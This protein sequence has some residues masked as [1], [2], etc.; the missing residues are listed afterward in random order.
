MP[1]Q[2]EALKIPGLAEALQHG[3]VSA[4]EF[5]SGMF[6]RAALR[7]GVVGCGRITRVHV[8]AIT[9]LPYSSLRF[10]IVAIADPVP[11]S[12][13]NVLRL[14]QTRAQGNS[15]AEEENAKQPAVTI[16]QEFV[17][18][19]DMLAALG[20]RLELDAVLLALPHDVHESAV[21][22]ALHEKHN[23]QAVI[24]EKPFGINAA[25]MRRML[26][27]ER[28]NPNC[29]LFVAEQSPWWPEVKACLDVIRS[30]QIGK[31]VSAHAHYFESLMTTDFWESAKK[32]VKT[33]WRW[34]VERSGGGMIMDG[35]I[36]WIRA[37]RIWLGDVTSVIACMS[38]PVAV[39]CQDG[40]RL[41]LLEGETISHA[42][43][44]FAC[45]VTAS[46]QTTMLA[47]GPV[48]ESA[49]PF[50]RIT[51]LKGELVISGR[52]MQPNQG[53]A[54]LFDR[55]CIE[56]GL[57]LLTPHA[58]RGFHAAFPDMW[59][60]INI[61]I[62]RRCSREHSAREAARDVAVALA[63]YES[64]RSGQWQTVESFE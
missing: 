18:L 23:L 29:S 38:S 24:V 37:L 52:S 48:C 5:Q 3:E 61:G 57:P 33:N 20:S 31:V 13:Q 51:G 59:R 22:E 55:N 41:P 8:E 35:G 63:L 6:G 25:S 54:T 17:S 43:M 9:S 32:D 45:G 60:S 47:E 15:E 16:A 27:A 12:R 39:P 34:S 53:G 7:L 62:L 2:A 40:S 19:S 56:G 49:S 42:L 4:D 36:H 46:F 10:N 14:L 44:Q 11:E 30:G 50:F 26:A 28:A 21:V 64:A 1:M 58:R